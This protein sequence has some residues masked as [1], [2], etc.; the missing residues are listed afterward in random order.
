MLGY[1]YNSPEVNL[2]GIFIGKVVDNA[3]PKALE[4]IKIRVIGVHDMENEDKKNSIWA[5]HLAPSKSNSGEIPDID[6]FL[7]VTFLQNDPSS[8]VWLGWVRVIK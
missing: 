7:Y 2:S 1:E 6:D 4:R 5:A 8:C 3:D